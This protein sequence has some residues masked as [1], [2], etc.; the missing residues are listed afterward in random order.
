[1]SHS[2]LCRR[3][4]LPVLALGLLLLFAVPADAGKPPTSVPDGGYGPNNRPVF[5]I[6]S[7]TDFFDTPVIDKMNG[8]MMNQADQMGSPIMIVPV[9]EYVAGMDIEDTRYEGA[10]LSSIDLS[11]LPPDPEGMPILP[12]DLDM[13]QV[14]VVGSFC[15]F[16]EQIHMVTP[17]AGPIAPPAQ[18]AF[19]RASAILDQ[20]GTFSTTVELASFVYENQGEAGANIN[21]IMAGI[22]TTPM[23]LSCS[24]C[25]AEG[26]LFPHEPDGDTLFSFDVRFDPESGDF[27]LNICLPVTVWIKGQNGNNPFNLGS[28]GVLPVVIPTTEHFDAVAELDPDTLK[29]GTYVFDSAGVEVFDGVGIV[30]SSIEDQDGDG[31]LDVVVHFD[32]QSIVALPGVDENTTELRFAGETYLGMCVEGVDMIKIV[33]PSK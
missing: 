26:D 20:L 30:K 31:D 29:I 22:F 10:D 9:G 8:G 32:T 21:D 33:P 19:F 1:M 11:N 13:N 27:E 28:N 12:E 6:I 25:V 18:E 3:A 2:I 23:T 16:T 5:F 17:D 24:T 4:L 14:T 15:T 7:L